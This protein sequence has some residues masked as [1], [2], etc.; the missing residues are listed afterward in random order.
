MLLEEKEKETMT[1]NTSTQWLSREAASV[2]KMNEAG[3][4]R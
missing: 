2:E 1:S 3:T 4:F